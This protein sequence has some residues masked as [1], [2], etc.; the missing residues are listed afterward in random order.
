[1]INLNKG[2]TDFKAVGNTYPVAGNVTRINTTVA[3]VPCVWFIPDGA[4]EHEIVIYIHGGA[5]IFGSADSH[6]PMVSYIARELKRKVL[7]VEYRLAPEHPFPAGLSD[8]IAVVNA[9]SEQNPELSFGMIADS[10]GGNLTM[11]TA[12][13]L[14]ETNGPGPQYIVLISPWVD[15]EC[16]NASYKRNE[17]K[18]TV[19]GRQYLMEAAKMY[20]SG[21]KLS[22]PHLSPVNGNF[23]GLAPV[24]ILCGTHEILEDDSINLHRQLLANG[25]RAELRL[26]SGELHV[27]PFMDINT[28]ASRKALRDMARFAAKHSI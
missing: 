15:L 14:Q 13:I 17:M 27:W 5:L 19:L 4:A 9:V 10:A 8:C 12:L 26:F 7:V 23:H 21:L 18:D 20:A 22:L 3:G 28:E 1:M 11:A 2:R 16:K 25:V 24:L 6:A